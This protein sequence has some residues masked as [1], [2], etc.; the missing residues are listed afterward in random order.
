MPKLCEVSSKC[1][2]CKKSFEKEDDLR[3]HDCEDGD[4]EVVA[5]HIQEANE[6][7]DVCFFPEKEKNIENKQGITLKGNTD[8]Y[9]DAFDGLKD[10]IWIKDGAEKVFNNKNFK[11]SNFKVEKDCLKAMVN[12]KL[13]NGEVGRTMLSMFNSRTM[14]LSRQKKSD[15]KYAM[16]FAKDVLVPLTK[17]LICG[18]VKINDLDKI[19]ENLT[20]VKNCAGREKCP[21]CKGEFGN[22][23]ELNQ[24]VNMMHGNKIYNCELCSIT[25][26][27][28]DNLIEHILDEH[29]DSKRKCGFCK[30]ELR[31]MV[32]IN[33]H[34]E[35]HVMDV[36]RMEIPIVG[37]EFTIVNNNC[38]QCDNVFE[39]EDDLR[40]HI[41]ECHVVNL[42]DSK[43]K[44]SELFGEK[45]P[46]RSPN[47]KM[48][49]TDSFTYRDIIEKMSNTMKVLNDKIDEKT[50]TN[51]ELIKILE[52]ERSAFKISIDDQGEI[53]K[54]LKKQVI[55]VTEERDNI[56]KEANM[57]IA[58]LTDDNENLSKEVK[59]LKDTLNDDRSENGDK[60]EDLIEMMGG[61]KEPAPSQ[62]KASTTSF[63][64]RTTPPQTKSVEN[65]AY[66]CPQCKLI[67]ENEAK[68]NVHIINHDEDSNL[69]CEICPF[70]TS[71]K[72]KLEI[73]VRI[74]HIERSK[75][76]SVCGVFFEEV[77]ELRKHAFREHKS[78]RPCKNF[79]EAES[80]GCQFGNNCHYSH[81]KV[82]FGMQRCFKCGNEFVSLKDLMVHR[83]ME[84]MELC[85]EAVNGSCK[86]TQNTCWFNHPLVN[87]KNGTFPPPTPM[88]FQQGRQ[89]APPFPPQEVELKKVVAS[90][91]SL[92]QNLMSQVNGTQ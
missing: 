69:A 36:N 87:R 66:Q 68:L 7:F 56:N 41:D 10:I 52:S 9:N 23:L 75:H 60:M 59:E 18:N 92:M 58:K 50:K 12:L 80:L 3:V 42:E 43:R 37:D 89:K 35:N 13:D 26:M 82:T 2:I 40:K 85:K 39:S 1:N 78:F 64:K 11:F 71:T 73:H 20:T 5:N 14:M 86:F 91:F 29:S 15:I 51:E 88:D 45:S 84:H 55:D 28:L 33:Q 6:H 74:T 81:V 67:C 83:K 61:K 53:V 57:S 49:K 79:F 46:S 8:E 65:M 4:T 19:K 27:F 38:L 31:T 30:E 70:Q 32:N 17:G 72:N 16:S 62:T 90:M 24:H 47:N 48:V 22:I 76:C 34:I 25:V 63:A 44:W 21:V 77:S 54:E